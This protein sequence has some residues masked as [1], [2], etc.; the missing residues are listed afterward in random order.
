MSLV[1]AGNFLGE[2]REFE[3][4]DWPRAL[5]GLGWKRENQTSH[6]LQADHTF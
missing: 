4:G 1:P 3:D 6:A 5:E 2:D